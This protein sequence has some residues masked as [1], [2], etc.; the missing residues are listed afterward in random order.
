MI[1]DNNFFINVSKLYIINVTPADTKGPIGMPLNKTI[2]KIDPKIIGIT[3]DGL[4]INSS[5]P[6]AV[7]IIISELATIAD[8]PKG[9]FMENNISFSE[10][11]SAAIGVRIPIVKIIIPIFRP[12]ASN[13]GKNEFNFNSF[14]KISI[15]AEI[16][17][18]SFFK[19]KLKVKIIS[20]II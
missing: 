15:E 2:P 8:I 17:N 12:L 13:L 11:L 4:D 3:T 9:D 5:Y 14:N 16:D 7:N 6:L 18:E 10:Y 1:Y 20:N 19:N